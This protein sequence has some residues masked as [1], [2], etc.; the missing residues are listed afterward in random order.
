MVHGLAAIAVVIA[1]CGGGG[2]NIP[3]G[4]MPAGGSYTGVWHSPQYG[5][6][7]L[8]QT[9]QQ[10]VGTYEKDE[11]TG[12]IQGTLH[13]NVLRFEWS[14]Q[15]EMVAGRAVT[16]R[17]RGYFRYEIGQDSDHYIRGEWGV[18]DNTT[19]GGEWNAVRDRRARPSQNAGSTGTSGG[20][21]SGPTEFDSADD[22]GGGG[23]GGGGSGG[24]GG[25]DLGLGDL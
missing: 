3:E 23:G 7:E 10:V 9:G 22:G 4:P 13:G 24:G 20:D 11:R 5:R 6:M 1:G 17:G 21:D 19:G 2:T 18:D 8:V 25:D 12:R 15:R 14:E 16:T